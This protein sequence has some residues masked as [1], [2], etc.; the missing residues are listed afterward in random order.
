MHINKLNSFIYCRGGKTA[1]GLVAAA[2]VLSFVVQ[3]TPSRAYVSPSIHR[4]K[5]R[6]YL[7]VSSRTLKTN[8][9]ISIAFNLKA[10]RERRSIMLINSVFDT[11][12][13]F[14]SKTKLF[15]QG[16]NILLTG[17]SGGLGQALAFQ[18][19]QCRPSKLILSGRDK[20]KLKFVAQKCT[21]I[22]SNPSGLNCEVETSVHVLSIN[23]ADPAS[24]QTLGDEALKLCYPEAIDVLINNGG[25]SSRSSFL[26]TKVDV[27]GFLMQVN[28]LS[29]AALAKI[30][31]PSMVKAGKGTII[32][33]CGIQGLGKLIFLQSCFY[34]IREQ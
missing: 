31:S 29:G 25:I 20:Q 14:P 34:K 19:A 32:W 6:N 12:E 11:C 18:L 13:P 24:V 17:A 9:G 33:I 4:R 10:T 8:A 30:V 2:V 5:I 26:E 28:F 1:V 27:D 3:S 16:K 23:L 21:E 22:A 15:Y 7:H